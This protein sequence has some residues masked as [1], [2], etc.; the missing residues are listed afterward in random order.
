MGVLIVW[1]ASSS[2]AYRRPGARMP[3]GR[4][5]ATPTLARLDPQRSHPLGRMLTDYSVHWTVTLS[6]PVPAVLAARVP[7]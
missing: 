1:R 6:S 5:R 2:P 7:Y 3:C 4:C